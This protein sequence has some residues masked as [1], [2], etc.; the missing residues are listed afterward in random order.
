[1]LVALK[2]FQ[3]TTDFTFDPA[4]ILGH[5][6]NNGSV[7]IVHSG[8]QVHLKLLKCVLNP[9]TDDEKETLQ[10]V[11]KEIAVLNDSCCHDQEFFVT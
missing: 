11:N 6:S 2:S 8:R 3:A 7:P 5:I 9:T 1:M 4:D 10:D